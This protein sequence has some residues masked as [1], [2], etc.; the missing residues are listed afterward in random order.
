MFKS[1][2]QRALA[3]D[4]RRHLGLRKLIP[5]GSRARYV[6]SA[7]A[8]RAIKRYLRFWRKTGNSPVR[9]PDHIQHNYRVAVEQLREGGLI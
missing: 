1:F 4:W 7:D 6:F 8:H 2:I 9:I 5:A 3:S